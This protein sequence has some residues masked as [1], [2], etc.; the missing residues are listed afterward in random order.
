MGACPLSH[1]SFQKLVFAPLPMLIEVQALKSARSV[2]VTRAGKPDHGRAESVHWNQS[3]RSL[4]ALEN[5][6]RSGMPR[7]P[8]FFGRHTRFQLTLQ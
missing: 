7:P 6:S 8:N 2:C 3:H 1:L 4:S 5:F